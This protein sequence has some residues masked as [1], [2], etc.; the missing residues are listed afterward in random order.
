MR[1]F[2]AWL[3]MAGA[4][5]PASAPIDA[6]L[7]A[8]MDATVAA[9]AGVDAA[10]CESFAGAWGFEAWQGVRTGTPTFLWGL[11]ETWVSSSGPRGG[12]CNGT[13]RSRGPR[14]RVRPRSSRR[15]RTR[16]CTC[17]SAARR[18]R[19]LRTRRR[20][21]STRS[22]SSRRPPTTHSSHRSQR[23]ARRP[24]RNRCRRRARAR[25]SQGRRGSK[26]AR[27]STMLFRDAT[28]LV[29]RRSCARV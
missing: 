9:D 11:R 17:R 13:R 19:D 2:V 27:P 28:L 22:T 21:R 26:L 29:H 25:R 16:S 5:G 12:R 7:D 14:G 6:G 18:S 10:A 15:A 3:L 23:H 20:T 24:H 1:C 4:C 8:A